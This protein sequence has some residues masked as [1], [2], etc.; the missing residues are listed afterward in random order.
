MEVVYH[1]KRRDGGAE[2]ARRGAELV[3]SAVKSGGE[4]AIVLATGLSQF[5]MLPV[6]AAEDVAWEKVTAFHLDEYVGIS[7][8]HTASFR[9]VLWREFVRKLP[10]P[11][12][13]F[14]WIDGEGDPEAECRRLGG[15]IS[16]R[17]IDVAFVGIGENGH[18]AFN[19][20][21]ADFNA[22]SPYL[23]VDLDDRCR[24]QQLGEGWFK[25]MDETPARAISMSIRQI[26]KSGHII[27]TCPDERKAEAVRDCLEGEV[28]NLHPASILRCH[29]S[30]RLYLDAGSASR[31]SRGD[32]EASRLP[33]PQPLPWRNS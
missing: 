15:I 17:P 24:R 14:H 13:A 25:S 8:R 9:A 20:P 29:P 12:K 16:R 32:G 33:P 3:R 30:V 27:A 4:A 7:P 5:D 26:M 22:E 28:S 19:D 6:L 11:L 2:A 10:V 21:P 1:E 18:L 23:V 31:L